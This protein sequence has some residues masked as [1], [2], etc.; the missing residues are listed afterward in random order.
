MNTIPTQHQNPDGLHQKYIIKKSNGNPVDK[1]S[2]YFVLRL[3]SGGDDPIH[4]EACRQAVLKYAE[5]IKNHLPH[6]SED[7]FNRYGQ[8]HY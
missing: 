1:E 5:L 8:H 2:E 4:T 3:D 7:I 6:L